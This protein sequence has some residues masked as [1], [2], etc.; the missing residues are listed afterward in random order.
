MVRNF[1]LSERHA[2]TYCVVI[3]RPGPRVDSQPCQ[4]PLPGISQDAYCVFLTSV[5]TQAEQAKGRS[6]KRRF[7]PWLNMLGTTRD[8]HAVLVRGGKCVLCG[9]IKKR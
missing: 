1:V 5:N 2:P 4:S 8:P 7:D 9:F 3:C 6:W